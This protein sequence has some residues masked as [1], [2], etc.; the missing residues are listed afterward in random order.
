M[1]QQLPG[2]RID[3]DH[4]ARSLAVVYITPSTIS[5]LTCIPVAGRGPKFRVEK[6]HA[7]LRFPDVAGIDLIGGRIPGGSG[8]TAEE[9]PF[10]LRRRPAR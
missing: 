6:R 1:P 8:V 10:G 3:R 7:T 9:P 4:I 2:G 5:G